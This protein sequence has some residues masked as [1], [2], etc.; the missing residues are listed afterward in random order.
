MKTVAVLAAAAVAVVVTAQSASSPGDGRVTMLQND[1]GRI[2][3][4]NGQ[5]DWWIAKRCAGTGPGYLYRVERNGRVIVD[6]EDEPLL[7]DANGGDNPYG[8]SGGLG[9]FAYQHARGIP[10][11]EFGR[12]G[13]TNTWWV[14]SRACFGE[15]PQN[16]L[17]GVSERCCRSSPPRRDED[18][19]LHWSID[20]DLRTPWQD[21]I[22]RVRYEYEFSAQIVRLST[23]VRSFCAEPTCGD[24]PYEHFAK[25]PKFAVQVVPVAADTIKVSDAFGTELAH[26]TGGHPRRGTGQVADDSRDSVTFTASGLNVVA[27]GAGG[28]WEDSGSG[29]DGW[30]VEAASYVPAPSVADGP[31]PLHYASGRDTRWDCNGGSPELESLR[32]WELV[33][34]APGYPLA[35]FFHGWE[36]GVGHNDCEPA[37]RHFPPAGAEFVN[38]FEY[39]FVR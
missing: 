24:A 8:S 21:P 33:G 18:G 13:G 23:T 17:V 35:A 11:F 29:L 22:L 7:D 27:R 25:E 32:Q 15:H 3:I 30:A 19:D 38:E 5:A 10:P 16:G 31:A 14:T 9:S 4:R 28:R 1:A 39:S 6:D 36:G 2:G 26:W 20:V 12:R 34:G 37:A